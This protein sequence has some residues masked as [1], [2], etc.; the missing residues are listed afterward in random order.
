MN[1][2]LLKAKI[3][4][5]AIHGKLV[6]QLDSEPAVEQIGEVPDEIPFEIPGKWKWVQLKRLIN[7]INGTSYKSGDTTTKGIRIIRGGNLNGFHI[8]PYKDDIF[9]PIAFY[10]EEKIVKD[11]D[12]VIVASTGS[13]EII[14]KPAILK[15][16][17]Q[18]Q[19]GA[20]LRIIRPKN[21]EIANYLKIFFQTKTYR[22]HI[23]QSV[24]GTNINNIKKSYIEDLFIPLPPL[25]EQHRIVAKINE[26]FSILDAIDTKQ[27]SLEEKLKLIKNKALDLAI[28]GKL[29]PQLDSEP[30]VEQ[31]GEIPDEIAFEI[32]EKWKLVLVSKCVSLKSG[33]DLPKNLILTEKGTVP[34]ITG[35]SQFS[36]DNKLIINRWTNNPTAISDTDDILITCKGTVGKI[37][38]NSIG[39]IHI[40]RQLM[41]IKVNHSLIFNQFMEFFLLCQINT[42]EQK[43][44]GII[45]G[46]TRQDILNIKMPLPSIEEQH[47]IV[48]KI[49][50]IFSFCDKAMELLH[51]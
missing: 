3:L 43:A 48:A 38:I 49:N 4:D 26:L 32:P 23:R 45:P 10:S 46:I 8:R 12:I 39:K 14:G 6:P 27:K 29:V 1:V 41:A 50:E 30:A 25:E 36:K 2:E 16:N 47:R 22:N 11:Y 34:Y 21:K 13:K 19:I 15:T 31:I 35:A 40:A 33:Q 44:R 42:I 20:F 18:C 37:T 24:S 5:L 28:H 9:L 17:L 7:I 51:K